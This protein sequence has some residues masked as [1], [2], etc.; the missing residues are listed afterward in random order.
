MIERIY[1]T[2]YDLAT[3]Y[4][5]SGVITFTDLPTDYNDWVLY[6]EITGQRKVIKSVALYGNPNAL[7]ELSVAEINSLGV[8]KWTYGVKL[9]RGVQENTCIPDPEISNKALFIVNPIQVEGV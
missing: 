2:P 5:D 1:D 6:M 9:C 4:G 3:F 8:G 7:V